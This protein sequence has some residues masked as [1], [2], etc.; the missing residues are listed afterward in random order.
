[1]VNG[2]DKHSD[3]D[4]CPFDECIVSQKGALIGRA[5]ILIVA[6]CWA[7]TD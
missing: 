4:T 1:M 7:M 3:C 2:C 6:Y 5:L